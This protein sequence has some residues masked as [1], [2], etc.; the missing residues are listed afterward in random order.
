M[1]ARLDAFRR[2]SELSKSNDLSDE[3]DAFTDAIIADNLANHNFLSA[4]S[5]SQRSGLR[6]SIR[7]LDKANQTLAEAL[8]EITLGD[9]QTKNRKLLVKGLK[10]ARKA[11]TIEQVEQQRLV[12]EMGVNG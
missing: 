3:L 2:L 1:T 4:L 8:S 9:G 5:V 12:S 10:R 7:E 11:I 6:K